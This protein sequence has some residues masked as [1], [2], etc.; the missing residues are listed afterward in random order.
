[1]DAM[2][3]TRFGSAFKC[4][5]HSLYPVLKSPSLSCWGRSCRVMGLEGL[6]LA[7]VS[8]V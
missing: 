8:I 4:T 7:K 3:R 5:V 1:M 2:K 6:V